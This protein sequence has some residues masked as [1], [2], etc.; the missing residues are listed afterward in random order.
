MV[1]QYADSSGFTTQ[2]LIDYY[3]ERAKNRVGLIIVEAACVT[4]GGRILGKQLGIYDDS[5]IPG[6]RKL[7]ESVKKAGACCFLQIQHGG[8]RASPACSGGIQPVAPSAIPMRRGEMPHELTTEEVDG[9]IEAFTQGTRRAKEAGFDGVELHFAHGYLIAQ[10]LSPLTN[11]RT[12][13]YGGDLESR[14]RLAVEIVQ[15]IRQQVGESYPLSVRI[16]GDEYIKGGLTLRDAQKVSVMLEAA[17]VNVLDVSGGYTAS[18][19]EGYL[20][21]LRP[22]S[23]APMAIPRGHLLHLAE[24]VKKVVKSPV[25]TVGRL[26]APDLAEEVIAKGKA[27]MVAIGRGLI[28]DAAFASKVYHQQYDDIRKCLA[29]DT[30]ALTMFGEGNLRCAVN[31]E[32]GREEEHRIKPAPKS[33]RVLVIGGG[34]GG[35]EAARVAALRGHKVTLMERKPYLGGNMVAA[36]AVSFKQDISYFTEYLSNAINKLDVKVCLDTDVNQ[37][38]VFALKPD[39]VILATGASP[40]MPAIPGIERDSVTDGVKVLEGK[41]ETGSKVVVV[42]AGM[43]GCEAAV[44][45]TQNGKEV[46][47]VSRRDTDFSDTGGLAPDMEP[48]LRRWFLFEIWPK[49]PI[50]AI[51]KSTFHEVTSEG[52]IV[53][54]REGRHRLIAGDTIVFATGMKPNNS[55]K[56]KLQG[57][58][59]ELYEVGDCI[60]PRRI[61]EAVEEAARVARLI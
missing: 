49:L 8:R 32:A 29:C 31:T 15:R 25:I 26:D 19:E 40:K 21:C 41:V 51:G 38:R 28:A 46:I 1:T 6:L 16:C 23:V 57:G 12:D 61:I 9:I 35:M 14:A 47:I 2:R 37:E 44:Y 17:G 10:F 59:P 43:T 42:G 53:Q 60:K 20:S 33:K 27:D 11:K 3:V 55:L 45:L 36:A 13:K 34:P 4:L 22:A 58:V 24:G 52:L 56:E 18:H 30:C 5:F 48:L 39:V 54:D 7:A 50:E